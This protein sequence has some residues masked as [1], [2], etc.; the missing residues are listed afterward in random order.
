MR[1]DRTNIH[2]LVAR[3]M[4]VGKREDNR[5]DVKDADVELYFDSDEVETLSIVYRGLMITLDYSFVEKLVEETR[6]DRS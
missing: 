5:F 4:I 3:S 1:D 2:Y 6:K